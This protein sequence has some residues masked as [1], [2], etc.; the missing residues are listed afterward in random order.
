MKWLVY[1]IFVVAYLLVTFFGIGPVLF[2][3]GSITE[4][5]ITLVVVIL[6]Y[7][8]LTIAFRFILKKVKR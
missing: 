4:R 3:D 7:A 1:F 2:A 6:I 8:V 5:M